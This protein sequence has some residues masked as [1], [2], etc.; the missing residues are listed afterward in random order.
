MRRRAFFGTVQFYQQNCVQLYYCS[1]LENTLHY[2]AL[3]QEG[4]TYGPRR[5]NFYLNNSLF[6]WNLAREAPKKAQCGPRTKIVNRPC[7]TPYTMQQ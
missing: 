7:F 2:Y 5:A 3:R 4:A 6:D 1:Q